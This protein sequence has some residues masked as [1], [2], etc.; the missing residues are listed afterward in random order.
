MHQSLV[1]NAQTRR[2][3]SSIHSVNTVES[4]LRIQHTV[5]YS[6]KGQLYI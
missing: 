6:K 1:L 2:A 4:Q 3:K 5:K